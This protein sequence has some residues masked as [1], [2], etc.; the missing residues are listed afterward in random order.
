VIRRTY[1]A[2][3]ALVSGTLNCWLA[4]V[5]C[6]GVPVVSVSATPPSFRDRAATLES[7]R[8][9]IDAAPLVVHSGYVKAYDKLFGDSLD[10]AYVR[11]LSSSERKQL[12]EFAA[13]AS[14]NGSQARYAHH[15]R[16]V[17]ETRLEKVE[18]SAAEVQLTYNELI[19]YRLF[20]AAYSFANRAGLK[21]PR[22]EIL[23][24][25]TDQRRF[26]TAL[27]L[28][29]KRH[30]FE[31]REVELDHGPRIIVVSSTGCPFCVKAATA[32]STDEWLER[33][34]R[35]H[36]EWIE[37]TH[38]HLLYDNLHAWQLRYP[39]LRVS[40]MYDSS[41]WPDSMTASIRA[42]PT[43]HF[44]LDGELKDTLMGWPDD[45]KERIRRSLN[46]IGVSSR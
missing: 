26:P 40:A 38:T 9:E 10:V 16:T 45:A 18:A 42:T 36:S 43:F 12:L 11:S 13:L 4:M 22:V 35:A 27:Y 20:D 15:M 41:E 32:I 39:S 24:S 33:A 34:F 31:R 1:A 7:L 28:T 19:S 5:L 25:V 6:M 17:A 30:R 14:W 46:K 2:Q 8:R 23:E 44:F 29:K 21:V 37:P 3:R